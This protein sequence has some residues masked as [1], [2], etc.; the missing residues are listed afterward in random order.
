MLVDN[1][2]VGQPYVIEVVGDPE[3][4]QTNLID[5]DGFGRFSTFAQLY[6][7]DFRIESAEQ[8]SLPAATARI[9]VAVPAAPSPPTPEG[10]R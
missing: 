10:N 3:R 7:T 8:L 4:L 9:Q 6:G 1:R 2:P 5:T